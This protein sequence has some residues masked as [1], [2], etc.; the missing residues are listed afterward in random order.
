MTPF[1]DVQAQM[2]E[3]Y[4]RTGPELAD[5]MAFCN[6]VTVGPTELVLIVFEEQET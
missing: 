4:E 2:S 3:Q 6:G 1:S 5:V